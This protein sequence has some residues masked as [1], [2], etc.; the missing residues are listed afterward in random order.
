M[1]P[2]SNPLL[3]LTG[4]LLTVAVVIAVIIFVLS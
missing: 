4:F 1:D 2:K 3:K